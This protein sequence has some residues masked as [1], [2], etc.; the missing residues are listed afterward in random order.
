M[1]AMTSEFTTTELY[2]KNAA[3]LLKERAYPHYDEDDHFGIAP[4][5]NESELDKLVELYNK[6]FEKYTHLK[7][8]VH[9]FCAD[10]D[11]LF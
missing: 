1:P 2:Q 10:V 7:Q 4:Y 5:Y 3:Q 8:S 6:L 11:N 9:E